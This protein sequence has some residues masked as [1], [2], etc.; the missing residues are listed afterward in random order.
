[1]FNNRK[2]KKQF[3]EEESNF[4]ISYSDLMAGILII[5]ILLFLYK[6][7]DFETQK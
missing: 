7:Q 1:M 3:R 6:I 2:V 4:W 5:F